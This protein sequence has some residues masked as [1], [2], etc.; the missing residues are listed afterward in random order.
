VAETLLLEIGCEELP[1][2]FIQPALDELGQLAKN[3]LADARL[4]HTR[5]ST[6]GTPR[7]LV[8][9]VDGLADR[10]EDRT[11]EVTGPAVRVAYDPSGQ[12]TPAARGFAKG[13][14]IPVESLERVSTP[15]GE[16]LLARVHDAGKPAEEVLPGLLE[17]WI[18]GLHFP[19]T[20]HWDG[21]ARFARPVR[22][23]VALRGTAV[24]PVTVFG[25]ASG[26]KSSGHR[27]I[28]PGW[29][30]VPK[31]AAYKELLREHGVIVEHEARAETI[32]AELARAASKL[33]G[34]AVEDRELIDEVVN[35]VEWPEAVV[36]TFDRGY[37]ELP[38]AVVVTAMRA[39]QRYFAVER[40]DRSLLPN[41]VMMR[42]GRGDGADEIRRGTEIV[43]RARLE[44]A[45]FYWENDLKGGLEAKV[46]ALKGIVWNERL[47][48]VYDRV[49]RLEL[50][51]EELSRRLAPKSRDAAVR[52]A[53]LCKADLASEMVRSGKE[54]T[55]L[56]G[57]IGAEYA[58]KSGEPPAVAQAIREH[59]LPQSPGDPIPSTTEG[60]LVSLADKLEAVVGGMRA[61]LEVSGSQDPYGLR[62]AGNGVIRI[63]I[64][65]GSR[66][67]VLDVACWLGGVYDK[68][69]VLRPEA[70]AFPAFWAQRIESALEERGISR[71][72]IASVLPVRPGDPL[73]VLSRAQAID[74][75]RKS[76]DFE[77]LMI[78]YRRGANLL[79]TA[80]PDDIPATGQPLAERAEA[81]G[82]RAEADLHLET[83]MA[84]QAVE[85][86]LRA[87]NPDYTSVLKHL[88]GLKP[89][90]DRF[91]DAVMVMDEDISARRRRL[92]LLEAVRQT[93]LR[94]ADFSALPSA[95]GQKSV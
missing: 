31:P 43:L 69:G 89:A 29:F 28:A 20:M 22:W 66:L 77:G 10:Q 86:Y 13:A 64:E 50:L 79:R 58:T 56:Q 9:L 2:G 36:G 78:G 18:L 55:T 6:D 70:D 75:I 95:P 25:V 72:T 91:F 74:A 88:L 39:H 5:V 32:R 19:K 4:T 41:F 30:E 46:P 38:R 23:L 48:T 17:K 65:S 94:I 51:V 8:L 26:K 47:G 53:R 14:G 63:L 12:P 49:Q 35:L 44:D 84:R 71:E 37:L 73:D 85:T 92:G 24:L 80:S 82:D 61:G 87:S 81:F 76:P 52:A 90:I 60:R 57:I 59:Y 54:F 93:F 83:K 27:T 16:Y 34:R 3:G 42:S 62:R 68:A 33:G 1:A 45:R 67:D 21:P 40:T 7:R 11:R 15:K